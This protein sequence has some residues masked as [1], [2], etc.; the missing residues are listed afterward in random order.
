MTDYEFWKLEAKNQGLEP[1]SWNFLET[2]TEVR[3]HEQWT[4]KIYSRTELKV[5]AFF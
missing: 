1:T 4:N 3:S 2:L 5:Q